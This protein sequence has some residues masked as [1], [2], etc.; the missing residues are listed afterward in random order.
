MVW[1]ESVDKYRSTIKVGRMKCDIIHNRPIYD[2]EFKV[3][4]MAEFYT[5]YEDV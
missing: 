3:I 5:N 4:T 2:R 1:I